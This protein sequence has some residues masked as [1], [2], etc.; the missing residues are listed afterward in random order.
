MK[1]S[2]AILN[3]VFTFLL[4]CFSTVASNAQV[5]FSPKD[6]SKNIGQFM[7]YY[8]DT[9]NNVQ[10]SDI[11]VSNQFKKFDKEVPDLGVQKAP[12]WLKIQVT[13]KNAEN[14]LILEF[15]QSPFFRI[16]FYYPKN[17][18][19]L[20][21]H[22]GQELPFANRMLNF[23]K[24]MYD[25]AI[26]TGT[27]ETYYFKI[28]SAQKLQ[29][30]VTLAT[31]PLAISNTLFSNLLFGIFFGIIAV[32]FF[33]NFFIYFTVNDSIYLYYVVYILVVG[34]TQATIEGY[35]FQYLWPDSPF[36][37]TRAFFIL[38]AL[39]NIT[40]LE[41]ARKFLNIKTLL[42]VASKAFIFFYVV[43][44]I[45]IILT[46]VGNFGYSYTILQLFAGVV[47]VFILYVSIS[48]VRKDYRPA[49][50]FLLAWIPLL[51]G[52]F[53]YVLKEFAVLPY[54][55]FT[56]YS[57]TIGSMLEVILLSFALADKINVYKKEK[58]VSQLATLSALKENERIVL[59][60][61]IVLEQ[62]V[63]ERTEEL[64]KSNQ[65][66]NSTLTDLKEAQSQLVDSEKMAGLGQ[67]TAGIA[68]EIN[69]P[70]NFV[71]SN[72]KPLELDILDLDTVIHMYESID[73]EADL[74]PQ[75]AKIES[76]K[77]QIDIV[78]VREEIKSLLSGIG[79]GARRTAE[80]IRSLKN[81]SRLD[82]NDTK[83]VDLNEG[84]ASTLVLVK[85]TF[86]DHLKVEKDFGELPLVECL[87]GKINQV[88]M[89]LITNAIHAIK[90][91]EP[92]DQEGVLS[93]KTW[94]E[95]NEVKISIKDSGTG[96]P[97]EVKQKIFEP[98][99]T[100]K[101]VGEGTGLGLSIVFRIIE[102]HHGNID[103]VTKLN[104]GTEF[105]IT[106]PVNSK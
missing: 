14:N 72:I 26:P 32:M 42:P 48:A 1:N 102:N 30:P 99:F 2:F 79:E 105:I 68:H 76:F 15:D 55:N 78:F 65:A 8:I 106:L 25:L 45:A 12:V 44:A 51:A 86:P 56:N 82:E 100:T 47:S 40:G 53:I 91:K 29:L 16:D 96:M 41:F 20:V 89:N 39:V 31:R 101:D 66:L 75:L 22:S 21:N 58:E 19:Y 57:I 52:I 28:I 6:E 17:G 94:Q 97:E 59:E 63:I 88:F 103:V 70:I 62:K 69:N 46:I 74:K 71:T 64:I 10:L 77:K 9:L 11:K 18:K 27:T 5:I 60:Q 87:P 98:F 50:F 93:I 35:T 95:G 61:N 81:F 73:P 54:N 37:A 7:G 67:L 38:T 33:Y 36:I 23:H 85:N 80:I 4:V 90:S 92:R 3:I 34:L 24:Y 49:K 104:Q 84:I 83:P 43:Y 13:N